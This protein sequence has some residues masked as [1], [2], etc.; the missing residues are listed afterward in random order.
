MNK[1]TFIAVVAGKDD[2]NRFLELTLYSILKNFNNA[3]IEE[4]LI[5]TREQDM[6]YFQNE[7]NKNNYNKD[8]NNQIKIIN[9][10]KVFNKK[11]Y[12]N[13]Q[14]QIILKLYISYYVK[15]ELYITL[16]SDMYLTKKI[17]INDIIVDNKPIV[18]FEK[19]KYHI[20]WHYSSKKILNIEF[21]END[22]CIGVTP[23]ILYTNFVKQL[24]KEYEKDILSFPKLFTEY[25]LYSLFITHKY[26]ISLDKLYYR[27]NLYNNCIWN[28]LDN[29]FDITIYTNKIKEQFNEKETIFSIIQSNLV[30]LRDISKDDYIN[31]IKYIIN[32]I[33]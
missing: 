18:N 3:D 11:V 31:I 24:L 4:F 20:D 17:S 33:I 22:D 14:L 32:N 19:I 27:K 10:K 7:L 15:T 28:K 13:Y 23:S 16:D 26:N 2:I 5:I 9:E 30:R 8:N 1:I 12:S 25:S 29:K 6:D 21:N